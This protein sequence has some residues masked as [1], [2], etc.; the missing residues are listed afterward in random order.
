MSKKDFWA[1]L[2]SLSVP[3]FILGMVVGLMWKQKDNRVFVEG[4]PTVC[5]ITNVGKCSAPDSRYYADVVYIQGNRM[6]QARHYIPID[7]L[8]NLKGIT[9]FC[10]WLPGKSENSNPLFDIPVEVKDNSMIIDLSEFWDNDTTT[11]EEVLK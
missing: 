8:R 3:I 9:Y 11:I 7:N 1:I 6:Q 4:L 10:F 5:K 2:I